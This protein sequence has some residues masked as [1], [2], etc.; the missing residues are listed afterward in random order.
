MIRV[1]DGIVYFYGNEAGVI[2]DGK[3]LVNSKFQCGELYDKLRDAGY[4]VE[5]V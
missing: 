1:V 5:W 3:A 2:K 4:T